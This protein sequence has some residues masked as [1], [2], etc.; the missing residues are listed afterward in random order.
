MQK[1][2][3]EIKGTKTGDHLGVKRDAENVTE[4]L[5]FFFF[6]FAYQGEMENW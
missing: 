5:L 6:Q 1:R 2:F 4:Y 3:W